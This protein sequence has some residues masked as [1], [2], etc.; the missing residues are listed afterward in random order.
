M[1]VW[2]HLSLVSSD[3]RLEN[4]KHLGTASQ[5]ADSVLLRKM[6]LCPSASARPLPAILAQDLR[7][8]PRVRQRFLEYVAWGA[9]GLEGCHVRMEADI[10]E[11]L[12]PFGYG[13]R[14]WAR[15]AGR[16]GQRLWVG[17]GEEYCPPSR[18][19]SA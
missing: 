14:P 18:K 4:A 5:S 13:R 10:E 6:W 16:D 3:N 11:F 8:R 17:G 2:S 9:T 12:Q 1:G 7:T 15:I 19:R